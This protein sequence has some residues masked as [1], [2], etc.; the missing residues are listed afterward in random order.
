M[1]L[2]R[3][4]R[5]LNALQNVRQLSSAGLKSSTLQY[6]TDPQPQFTD[7]ETQQLLQS[8]TQLQLD[9]VFRKRTVP[10]NSVHTQFMTTAQ[11]EKEFLLTIEK[12]QQLLQM[13]PV[14]KI[15]EDTERIISKDP[16]LK[17][18]ATTKY[19]FT[20]ITF[21]LPQS[22]RKV[23]VRDVDGTLSYA[24]LD[25]TKRMN[26]LY[27][28]LDG[29]KFYTPRMF[30][31][32]QLFQRC[33]DEHKYEFI[34][35]RL[36]VQYEPYEAEFHNI[37]AKVFEHLN[38]SKQFDQLR[39]TRHFGPMAFFYAWHRCIDDLLYDMIRRDYLL[40]AV[41]LIA[42]SYKIHK[43]PLDYQATL[44]QLEELQPSPAVKALAELRSGLRQ[45][46]AKGIENE[47]Q[48]AIGKTETDFQ[49]DEISLRFIEQYIGSEHALKKVQLELAVQTLKELNLEKQQL[50]EGLKKAHGV[51]QQAS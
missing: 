14:V 42:L 27:F 1:S 45:H 50:Y 21:G 39:S 31:D 35:D 44:R 15:K 12:A 49:A 13:P 5:K 38:E 4:I 20:D 46:Q 23:V 29:R 18:F 43:V 19:V 34:L 28:P 48:T 16:A 24:T 17:D 51:Q 40:N 10:D 7:A 33:L 8:M 6:A 9:K 32:E 30:S 25:I 3:H 47:I 26:Q 37:S 11:L 36:T 2:F 41:Q 22:E